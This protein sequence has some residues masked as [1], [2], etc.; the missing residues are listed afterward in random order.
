LDP[1]GDDN[2]YIKSAILYIQD[3]LAGAEAELQ[4]LLTAKPEFY[5]FGARAYL[6]MIN[7]RRGNFDRAIEQ[8]RQR[9]D[10]AQK[11]GEKAWEV[12]ARNSLAYRYWKQGKFQMAEAEAAALIRIADEENL[13]QPKIAGLM[14]KSVLDLEKNSIPEASQT[15]EEI[16]KIIDS[17]LFKKQIRWYFDLLGYIELH[18]NDLPKAIKYF[19]QA[20]SLDPS[21]EIA[22]DVE[23]LEDLGSAYFKNG[24]VAKARQVYEKINSQLS[25]KWN[26]DI[27]V[28]S[29][30]MLGRIAEQQGDKT[31]A[32][33]FYRKFLDL[34]K[35]ADPGLPE[36][37]E[38]KKRSAGLGSA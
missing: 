4:K 20:V 24:D 33:G 26:G 36:V 34:W 3:N 27:Y 18:K 10:L 9:L 17:M 37:E 5:P 35:D 31:R 30:Y 19:E 1:K 32:A 38:A 13:I 8:Q 7:V 14:T 16:K 15:A 11:V 25:S 28:K 2:F 22:K 23:L 6:A 29:F 21:P 12:S